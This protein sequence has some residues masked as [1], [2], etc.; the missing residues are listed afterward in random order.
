[1]NMAGKCQYFVMLKAL[2]VMVETRWHGY[3][4]LSAQ[5]VE[6]SYPQPVDNSVDKYFRF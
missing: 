6:K 1:M 4:A 5:I 3:D 2:F